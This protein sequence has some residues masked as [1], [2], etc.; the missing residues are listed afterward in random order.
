MEF[1]AKLFGQGLDEFVPSYAE[2]CLFVFSTL[3]KWH[4]S[5]QP[6]VVPICPGNKDRIWHKCHPPSP[7]PH[8]YSPQNPVPAELTCCGLTM[9][10]AEHLY[11][12]AGLIHLLVS[13]LSQWCESTSQHFHNNFHNTAQETPKSPSSSQE[14]TLGNI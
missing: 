13:L 14:C 11:P 9:S 5:K 7:Y 1:Q 12:H 8:Y 2:L 6:E 3:K 4:K 10:L